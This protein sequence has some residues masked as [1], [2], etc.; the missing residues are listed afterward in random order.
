MFSFLFII[1]AGVYI[2]SMCLL[3]LIV[4]G[5]YTSGMRSCGVKMSGNSSCTICSH[6]TPSTTTASQTPSQ[7]SVSQPRVRQKQLMI[8]FSGPSIQILFIEIKKSLHH[9]I[10]VVQYTEIL[11]LL[12][13]LIKNNLSLLSHLKILPVILLFPAIMKVYD[14]L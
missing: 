8:S 10:S 6:S 3:L 14:K 7:R 13:S 1:I 4:A 11:C 2:S 5:V 12:L 9:L